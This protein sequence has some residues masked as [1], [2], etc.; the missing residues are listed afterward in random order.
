MSLLREQA[1]TVLPTQESTT[2]RKIL[3]RRGD[4]ITDEQTGYLWN[5]RIPLCGITVVFGRP[6]HGKSTLGAKLAAHVTTGEAWPDGSPCPRGDV[7]YLKGEGSDASI[8]DRMEYAG[9]KASKYQLAG[10]TSD[11]DD[12]MIDLAHDAALVEELLDDTPATKLVIIDTLDS[13]FPSMRMIDN[14]HIRRCLWPIQQLVE[15]RKIALVLFA[16]TNKGGYADPLD[17]LSGGRAIGGAA[18]AIWYLGKTEPDADDTYFAP[19]KCNDFRPADAMAFRIDGV[20]DDRP[21]Y[22]VWGDPADVSAWDLEKPQEKARSGDKVEAC[23]AWLADLLVDG[24]VAAGKVQAE[25]SDAGFGRRVLTKAKAAMDARTVARAGTCPPVYEVYIPN[26]G[27]HTLCDPC[28]GISDFGPKSDVP[29]SKI[30]AR[31]AGGR[32]CGSTRYE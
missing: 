5:K 10:R 25:A 21:G 8:R 26:Q 23:K 30:K 17:R 22:V 16:H 29:T 15:Q 19:V 4:M 24:P 28:V 14:A 32:A 27:A 3:A 6:G 18:R 31:R 20:S 11:D 7:I 9:A 1:T 2:T 13:M 12:A